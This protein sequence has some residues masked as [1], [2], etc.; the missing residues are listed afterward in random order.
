MNHREQYDVAV[1][2]AGTAGAAV[3]GFLAEHGMRVVCVDR[4]PLDRAG[5]HWINGVP[6]SAF[7]RAGLPLPAGAEHRGGQGGFHL[8]AGQGPH[9]LLIDNHGVLEVDMRLL[10]ARLQARAQRL[11]V[12]FVA[13]VGIRG[14]KDGQLITDRG[15]LSATWF[16]D[17]SGLTGARLLD[18]PSVP[19]RHICVAA[20]EVRRVLDRNAARTYFA[21]HEIA[22]GEVLCFTG[23]AGG[24]SILNLRLC[25]DHISILTG[26]I[27]A[28]GYPAYPS[29]KAILNTFVASQPWI[30]ETLFGG[31]RA[32]P[33][34]RPRDVLARGPIALLGDAGCQVF[35]AHGSGI[36]AGL[37]AARVLADT[38]A[39]IKAARSR[40]R[41]SST[42]LHAYAV[43]WQRKHGGLLAAYDLFRRFSQALSAADI[44]CMMK[45]GLMD[46][47]IGRAGLEQ[48]LPGLPARALPGKLIALARCPG[49]SARL[50]RIGVRMLAVRALYARY[51]RDPA[52]LPRWSRA[53]AR[54]FRDPPD[55]P[56]HA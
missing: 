44:E 28:A 4:R 8:V 27:P 37:V 56:G 14:V 19:A 42:D 48:T 53:V 26:S 6:A 54:L 35:P 22:E 31:A 9:R 51:P 45:H 17:A 20:Q 52:H 43:A 49:L 33:V 46:P 12:H 47:D 2:G 21:R 29:G 32:I 5:A 15:P 50:A 41:S 13:E 24:Y 16:I 40:S 18:Q 25:G 30:G 1:V 36:G 11:G 3:A 10:V 55:I 39:A 7:E 38:V 23:I 34:R